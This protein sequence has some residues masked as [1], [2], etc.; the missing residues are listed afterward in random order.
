MTTITLAAMGNYAQLRIRGKVKFHADVT[1]NEGG[2][3]KDL[4]GITGLELELKAK[5]DPDGVAISTV[6]L[7]PDDLANGTLDI[8]ITAAN[9]E[10]IQDGDVH[11]GI[12]DAVGILSGDSDPSLLFH[13]DWILE[14]GVTG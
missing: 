5:D 8:D 9:T 12:F 10:V 6:A 13:G 11:E 2:S 3:A 14:K 7:T 1:V 4:T